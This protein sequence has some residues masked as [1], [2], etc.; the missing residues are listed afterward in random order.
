MSVQTDMINNYDNCFNEQSETKS[1]FTDQRQEV[2]DK[3]QSDE[4]IPQRHTLV[5]ENRLR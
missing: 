2:I 3:L 1:E 4:T 5:E